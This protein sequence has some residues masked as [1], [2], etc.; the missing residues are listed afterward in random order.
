MSNVHIL[1]IRND[2]YAPEEIVKQLPNCPVCGAKAYL[3]GD[4]P[5]GFWMGWSVGCPR[6]YLNDGI[7]GHDFN[8]P[9]ERHFAEHGF[10]TKE[11]AAAW[12][13]NR[14]KLENEK[15]GETDELYE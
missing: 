9:R 14:V 4:A 11:E 5:D 3:H 8:T 2:E 13:N 6:Y 1:F 10:A 15:G 12:W 7:H